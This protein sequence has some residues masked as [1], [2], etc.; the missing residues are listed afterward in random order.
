MKIDMNL[1]K[2][3]RDATLAPLKDCTE[4]LKEAEGD[5]D[6]AHEILQKKWALQAAKKADRETNEGVVK[7]TNVNGKVV[8]VKVACETDFVAKNDLF[9]EMVNNLIQALSKNATDAF[10][11]SGVEQ[12]I[13]E[14][15]Q[16]NIN[17]A[18]AK[19]GENMKLVDALVVAKNAYVYNHP[20]DKISSII[21]YTAQSDNAENTAKDVALQ[22]AAMSPRYCTFE[23]IPVDQVNQRKNDLIA[24]MKKSWKPADIIEKIVQGKL[25][26]EFADDVLLEQEFIRDNSKKVKD[27]IEGNISIEK[28]VRIAI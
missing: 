5:L 27:V 28:F 13:L 15:C 1:L 22:V 2:K 16:E 11:I 14:Q 3:L 9:V 20:G 23:E 17:Q 7:A 24:E 19:I 6:K 4:A 25:M 8:A 10:D 26:K 21:F 12:S 18:I